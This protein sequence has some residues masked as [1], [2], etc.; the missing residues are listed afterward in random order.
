MNGD[1]NRAFQ[2]YG[3]DEAGAFAKANGLGDVEILCEDPPIE[4]GNRVWV[5][6]NFNGVQDPQEPPISGIKVVLSDGAGTI[7]EA[8]TDGD[9]QYYFSNAITPTYPSQLVAAVAEAGPNTPNTPN[10]ILA[11][12]FY[13]LPIGYKA[14]YTVSVDMTQPALVLYQLTSPNK[15]DASPDGDIRDSDGIRAGNMAYVTFAT[16]TPNQNDHSFDFGF[17]N[18][19]SLGNYVWADVGATGV[20]GSPGF[21]NGSVDAGE[22]GIPGVKMEL[23]YDTN[24]TGLFDA[25]DKL[26][27]TTTTNASGLYLFTNLSATNSASTA[28]LVVITGTNFCYG[29]ALFEDNNSTGSVTGNSDLNNRDHG[30][31]KAG[32]LGCG[33]VV[34]SSPVS[35]TIG[36]EPVNDDDF[37]PRRLQLKFNAGLWLLAHPAPART[38]RKHWRP[39]VVRHATTTALPSQQSWA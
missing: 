13:S 7:A 1:Q 5:D 38:P 36:G 16:G 19:V 34:A 33:D 8:I 29:G 9:G 22:T 4:I 30:L 15:V 23:Y 37:D 11:S 10:A 12:A 26:I 18:I 28:Y 27:S 17:N 25:G 24:A 6:V 20:N 32:N 31:E 3:F 2:V 35:L 21:N 14:T 39:G